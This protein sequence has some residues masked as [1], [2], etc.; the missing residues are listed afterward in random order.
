MKPFDVWLVV[1]GLRCCALLILELAAFLFVIPTLFNLHNDL[2]TFGAALIAVL[3]V[4][5]G[6]LWGVVL[7]REVRQITNG[8]KQ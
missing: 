7:T 1:F 5:G 4:A 8:D 6:G 3:A 2:A